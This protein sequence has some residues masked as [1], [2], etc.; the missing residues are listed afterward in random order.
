M[1]A[2]AWPAAA[3]AIACLFRKEVRSAIAKIPEIFDRMK[4]VK[5]FE[6]EAQ[7]EKIADQ[8][9]SGEDSKGAISPTEFI[10]AERIKDEVAEVGEQAIAV[11][12]D[13]L[14]VEYDTIRREVDPSP[15]RTRSMTQILVR[16]RMLGPSM[17]KY[18][19]TY[20]T[21]GSAGSRLAAVAM[22][23]IQPEKADIDWLVRRF[24]EESPFV[25]YHA[26]LALRNIANNVPHLWAEVKN[27]ANAAL[28]IVNKFNGTP[29]AETVFVLKALL[30]D[31]DS[32]RY[33]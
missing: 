26:A 5:I 7:L 11:Q 22:M 3:L 1:T 16:M 23:Q 20:M 17:S 21:S 25:F 28:D 6:I 19:T 15:R 14:C 18:M 29:D 33:V 30:R 31:E 12:L 4:S 24:K 27:A 2:V 32:G 9:T 13:R 8:A 10:A